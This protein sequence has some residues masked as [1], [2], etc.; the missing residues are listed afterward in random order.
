MFFPQGRGAMGSAH[1][2]NV[3]GVAWNPNSLLDFTTTDSMIETIVDPVVGGQIQGYARV[4]T[5]NGTDAA[6]FCPGCELT[7]TFSGYTITN[8]DPVTGALTF[9]GGTI[10]VYVDSTPNFDTFLA[11][12]AGD[13]VLWLTLTGANHIDAATLLSG[14]PHSDPTP[15]SIDVAGDGRG[16]L[17]VA[18][19]LAAACFDTN[20]FPLLPAGFADFQFTSSFQLLPG[21]RRSC[22]MT[23]SRMACSARMT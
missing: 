10:N 3:G 13:G 15:A 1:A 6:T 23:T 12:T 19:G 17:D 21:G 22:R 2:I 16:F 5:L 20:T 9:N 8:V 7:Y 18:G 14:T 11:S 4:Q